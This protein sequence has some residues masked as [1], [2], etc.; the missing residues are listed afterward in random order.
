MLRLSTDI[1]INEVY[2]TDTEV[3][4]FNRIKEV[5]NRRV[6]GIAWPGYK[7]LKDVF[8]EIS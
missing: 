1:S 6:A 7:S 3:A 4:Q 8:D 5:V 2:V